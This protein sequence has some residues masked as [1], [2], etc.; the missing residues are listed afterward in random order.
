MLYHVNS[1]ATKDVPCFLKDN[2]NIR[3]KAGHC[4]PML[5]SECLVYYLT[6]NCWLWPL[7]L[8]YRTS[9]IHVTNVASWRLNMICTKLKIRFS[10][11]YNNKAHPGTCICENLQFTLY[12]YVKNACKQYNFTKWGGGCLRPIKLI[13]L[14]FH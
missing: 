4:F 6:L 11:L 3:F 14:N 1:G 8:F 5:P 13:Q 7:S 2:I 10:F 9:I 12:S